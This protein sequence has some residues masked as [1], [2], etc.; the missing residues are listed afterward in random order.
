MINEKAKIESATLQHGVLNYFGFK[1]S[2]LCKKRTGT[3][4]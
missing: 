1:I 3:L 4:V 2:V